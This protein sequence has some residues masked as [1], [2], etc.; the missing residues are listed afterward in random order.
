MK[1]VSDAV[2]DVISSNP[3]LQFGLNYRLMNLT[4]LARY[5][6]PLI[7]ARTK[8]DIGVS[9]ITMALSRQQNDLALAAPKRED[10]LIKDIAVHTQLVTYT[11]EKTAETH[12]GL[13]KVTN[14]IQERGDY[15]TIAEG[16]RELTVIIDENYT[17]LLKK[18]LQ[19]TPLFMHE[20]VSAISIVFD[21]KYSAIPGMLYILMQQ[22]LLQ[23]INLIE[24]SSTYT[25][26]VLYVDEVDTQLAF[27]SLYNLFKR[28]NL[29]R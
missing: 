27:D 10:F 19:E 2:R 16:I 28:K 15:I 14:A 17:P 29:E 5:I 8:K 7:E 21:P 6:E 3:L 12:R 11:F 9:A 22:L 23:N 13:Q 18:H 1:K 26:F 25:S 20:K 24:I 4:Q